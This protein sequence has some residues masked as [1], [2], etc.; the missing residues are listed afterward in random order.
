MTQ[1]P[2]ERERDSDRERTIRQTDR[3][4]HGMCV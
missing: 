3:E 1:T 2:G 4:K